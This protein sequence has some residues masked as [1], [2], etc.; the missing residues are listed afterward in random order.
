V[1]YRPVAFRPPPR[2]YGPL[3]YTLALSA[4]AAP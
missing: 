4:P 3:R 1:R 2:T